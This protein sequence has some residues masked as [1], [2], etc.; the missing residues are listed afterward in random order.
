MDISRHFALLL[1]EISLL[2]RDAVFESPVNAA[3][4]VRNVVRLA[5]QRF[6]EHSY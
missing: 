1:C 5:G 6:N 2:L 4:N 3:V